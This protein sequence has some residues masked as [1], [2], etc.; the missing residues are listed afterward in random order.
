MWAI[1]VIYGLGGGTHVDQTEQK[2]AK[3]FRTKVRAEIKFAY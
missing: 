2:I 3:V 1:L